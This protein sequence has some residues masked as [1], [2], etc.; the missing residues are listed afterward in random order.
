[1]MKV[2][3]EVFR[4][5]VLVNGKPVQEYRGPGNNT[6]VEGRESSKFELELSNLTPRRLLVHPAVDGLS[7]MTGKPAAQN[8]SQD[9]YVL[10]P[11]QTMRLP[12]W[13]LDDK[14]VAQFFFAGQG[15]SYAE[16]TGQPLNKGVIACPVW[17]EKVEPIYLNNSNDWLYMHPPILRGRKGGRGPGTFTS[18]GSRS[19]GSDGVQVYSCNVGAPLHPDSYSVTNAQSDVSGFAENVPHRGE[20]SLNNLGTGFGDKQKHE[21]FSVS[22]VPH[23]H[24]TCTAIIYY[25]TIEGLRTRGIKIADKPKGRAH[26]LPDLFPKTPK[27][28]CVPPPGWTE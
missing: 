25:D 4:L 9:G 7:V 17:E 2:S 15:N 3:S 14:Q 19:M 13:R 18:S 24:P 12:G 16:Q 11:Y 27:T 8:D 10:S 22:F 5:Q 21:V 23:D 28:G 1:M 20:R 6:F 26:R